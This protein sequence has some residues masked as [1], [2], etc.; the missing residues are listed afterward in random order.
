M[1][2]DIAVVSCF[3]LRHNIHLHILA[4]A[5]MSERARA[6]V[7]IRTFVHVSCVPVLVGWLHEE[8]HRHILYYE[9]FCIID[10]VL[11][12]IACMLY[13]RTKR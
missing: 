3:I 1:A 8:Y 11:L 12:A 9:I 5:S 4:L 13:K 2:E 10:F 6:C 7:G